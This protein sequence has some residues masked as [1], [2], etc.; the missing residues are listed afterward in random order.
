MSIFSKKEKIVGYGIAM[1]ET[2]VDMVKTVNYWISTGWQPHGQPF[3][4]DGIAFYQ[5]MIKM[6]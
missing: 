2:L 1:G 4:K 6:Y 5:P 3:T